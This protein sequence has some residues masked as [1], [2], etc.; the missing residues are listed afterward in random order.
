M[1]MSAEN[2]IRER[3]P[4]LSGRPWSRFATANPQLFFTLVCTNFSIIIIAF[5]ER[6]RVAHALCSSHVFAVCANSTPDISLPGPPSQS[7]NSCLRLSSS[8]LAMPT[9]CAL[10]GWFVT[11]HLGR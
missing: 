3:F 2:A 1:S 8:C 6:S 7:V 11:V 5:G 4:A 10:I 9:G